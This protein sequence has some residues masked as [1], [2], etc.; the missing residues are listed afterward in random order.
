MDCCEATTAAMRNSEVEYLFASATESATTAVITNS[1]TQRLISLMRESAGADMTVA[2]IHAK[3]VENS[4]DVA[5]FLDS[6]PVHVAPQT[7]KSIVLRPFKREPPE[8][9]DIKKRDSMS[10]GKVLISVRL[11]GMHGVPDIN[12]WKSWL[13][14]GIPRDVADIRIQGVFD[15]S[16]TLCL[17][18][19]PIEV[20]DMM[21]GSDA[22]SFIEYVSSDNKCLGQQTLPARHRR[23]ATTTDAASAYPGL[24][25]AV[26]G[27]IARPWRGSSKD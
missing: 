19:V 17:L 21:G 26:S 1:F 22:Y 16:S 15:T 20:W 14:Q 25:E 18:T 24:G 3:M 8:L 7:K 23:A 2:Q 9:R 27:N 6:S 5:N 10:R 13:A 11:Q 12:Q 4:G